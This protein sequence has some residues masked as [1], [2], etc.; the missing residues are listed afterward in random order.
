MGLIPGE[1]Y[2]A[3]SNGNCQGNGWA[4]RGSNGEMG[5]LNFD[6]YVYIIYV[7]MDTDTYVFWATFKYINVRINV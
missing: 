2:A 4:T 7:C 6:E 1:G 5:Q 3:R